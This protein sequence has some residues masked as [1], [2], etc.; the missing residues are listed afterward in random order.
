MR[1]AVVTGGG[2]AGHVIPAIPVIEL[3]QAQGWRVTFVGSDSGLE[4][5]LVAPLRVDY[6]SVKTGKL[7][8]YFSG[9]NF[10]DAFRIPLGVWQAFRL[11]GHLK[12]DVVFSK[13]GFVSFPVVFAAW[14]RGIPVVAHESDLTPGLANRLAT[15]FVTSFCVNFEPTVSAGIAG[16]KRVVVTGTPLRDVLTHGEAQRGLESMGFDGEKPVVVVTGGS[17]GAERL[18]ELVREALG[19][20]CMRYDIMHVC[21]KGKLDQRLD[22]WP[23][24]RQR[25]FIGDGWGD[26]LAAADIVVSRAG[27]N[28]LYELIALR[29]PHLLIPLSAKVSRGD[30]IEN[31]AFAASRGFSSVVQESALSSDELVRAI[32]A[33]AC[34][35]DG[36]RAKLEAF[37]VCDSVSLIVAELQ[38]AVS[39]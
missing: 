25:E 12:P 4:E 1:H 2:T 36:W 32:D 16:A 26:V 18:N 8:R 30:Q 17:L 6:H 5:S 15:P 24:Y 34:D 14:V 7:R 13:G 23:G 9:Q 28:T 29:K 21:G 22:A 37:E 3:L 11:L 27:A 39:R 20:L 33:I 19:A 38:R 10:I 31:A 35:L